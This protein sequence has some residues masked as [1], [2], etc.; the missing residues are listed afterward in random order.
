MTVRVLGVRHH[1]PA[2]ARL[3]EHVLRTERPQ[4][5]LIEGPADFNSRLGELLMKH[6]APL[7]IFSYYQGEE[8]THAC[9]SPFCD[10]SPEWVALRVGQEVGAE[11]SFI[12]LPAWTRPFRGVQNRYADRRGPELDYVGQLCRRLNHDGMDSLWDHLFE[13][14]LPPQELSSRLDAYFESLRECEA[15]SESDQQRE[16]FMAAQIGWA[17]AEFE[18][19]LVVCGGFHKPFL[20]Q[21]WQ[22]SEGP[23]PLAPTPPEGVRH[24]SYLVPYSFHRLDSFTGYGAGMPSPGFYQAVWEQGSEA[25]GSEMTRR[26]AR[27]LREKKQQV[28]SADLIAARTMTSGLMRLR[29]HP[30][31]ARC[32]LL[33]GF[34]SALVKE[35][36]ETPLPWNTRGTLA[37]GTHPLLV[38]L[39]AVFSGHREGNLDPAT[40]LP[41]LVEDAR[42]QLQEHD[43]MPSRMARTVTVTVDSPRSHLL[44]RLTLL[45]VPGFTCSLSEESESW[46]LRLDSLFDSALIE[47]GAWGASVE[48][49]ARARLLESVKE[50][51]G[52][53]DLIAGLLAQAFRAG[54]GQV[55]EVLLEQLQEQLHQEVNFARLGQAQALVLSLYRRAPQQRL[56][57]LLEGMC[58]R[59]LWLFEALCG[60][61]L[62][63]DPAMIAGV[64]ALRDTYHRTRELGL[65]PTAANEVMLRRSRD[66]EAPPT[67]RG[68]ALGFLWSGGDPDGQLG[69]QSR[70][71]IAASS[72]PSELGDFL[73]GLF[74]L[75]REEVSAVE[76]LMRAVDQVITDFED[77]DFLIACPSLRLAFSYFPPREREQIARR[78]LSFHGGDPVAAHGMVRLKVSPD[79]LAAAARL[80]AQVDGLLERF[81]LA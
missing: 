52:R 39:V 54:L 81:G 15:A 72:R 35:A 74:G 60:S 79:Q 49:A 57:W 69:A 61:T 34:A 28:S 1:S 13:Q 76:G 12:D 67:V 62:P 37:R 30:A 4:I 38:E 19:V 31:A 66:S 42:R 8:G 6:K 33:D 68:A 25:A 53:M 51:E 23:R 7:A 21:N 50:A 75:A 56:G 9:W 20:E 55:S 59:G 29:G 36:I 70:D 27:R 58:E 78:I 26:V 80:E 46:S 40:P 17:A 3:V 11:L 73:A 45:Q 44:H 71:I 77:Q 41:P 32:D 43:L 24:G 63:A 22:K 10:Y 2:C 18:S 16:A 14:P 64:V 47:A 5:V 65:E 48:Q